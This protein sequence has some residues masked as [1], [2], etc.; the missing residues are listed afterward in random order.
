MVEPFSPLIKFAVK[1]FCVF[2]QEDNA[3]PTM[4][5]VSHF[6]KQEKQARPYS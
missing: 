1:A 5:P 6:D 3:S 2:I 4:L